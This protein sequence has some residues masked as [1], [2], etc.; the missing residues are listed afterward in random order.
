M[1]KRIGWTKVERAERTGRIEDISRAA[2][3]RECSICGTIIPQGLL[4]ARGYWQ[5]KAYRSMADTG[6]NTGRMRACVT[7][8]LPA[9]KES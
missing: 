4:Y 1:A 9:A 3:N 2:E 6:A 8:V 7:C 5:V